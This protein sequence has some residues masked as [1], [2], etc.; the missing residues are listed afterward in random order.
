VRDVRLQGGTQSPHLCIPLTDFWHH[1]AR[2][3][4]APEGTACNNC[5]KTAGQASKWV[6][7]KLVED[8]VLCQPCSNKEVRVCVSH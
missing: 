3:T 5:G 1:T 2:L 8:V 6:K 4:Q 7:S